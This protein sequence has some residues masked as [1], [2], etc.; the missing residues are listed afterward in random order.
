MKD[1]KLMIIYKDSTKKM[2][3]EVWIDNKLVWDN[4]EYNIQWRKNEIL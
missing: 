1:K 4:G 3:V 2:P